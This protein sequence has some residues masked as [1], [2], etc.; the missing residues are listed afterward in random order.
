M[1]PSVYS[2][3]MRRALVAFI[4][5]FLLLSAAGCTSSADTGESVSETDVSADTAEPADSDSGDTTQTQPA[6]SSDNAGADQDSDQDGDLVEE[7]TINERFVSPLTTALGVELDQ[8][9][10]INAAFEQRAQDLITEC[11]AEAG[12]EYAPEQVGTGL[13]S[14]DRVTELQAT[15]SLDDFI[16]SY[17]YGLATLVELDFR[18]EGVLRFAER[19]LGPPA[20]TP[21]SE[22]EQEAFEIALN[23]SSVQD[24]TAEQAQDEVT[25]STDDDGQAPADADTPDSPEDWKARGCRVYGYQ[26][27]NSTELNVFQA[28][29][30]L[31]GDEYNDMFVRID[32]DPRIVAANADWASC[33]SEQG[34]D[35]ANPGEPWVD[36]SEQ[37]DALGER[38]LASPE[39]LGLFD[40]ALTA[41]VAAMT[42]VERLAF[43]EETGALQGF[44]LV[45]G[46]SDEL[47]DLIELELT[48]ARADF[49][50]A[51]TDVYDEVRFEVE[52]AFVE[53][54]AD[55]I[56]LAATG[57]TE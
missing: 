4:V 21:R 56:A 36:I 13:V 16:D 7:P 12:F 20:T 57:K 32:N 25:G 27:A 28:L 54:H 2:E 9:G 19:F 48:V 1:N 10:A 40:E 55:L 22:A 47:D 6:D 11:M 17:G 50:C 18:D 52:T 41:N 49:N 31:L 43:F 51:D 24:L 46:L 8:F 39:V 42:S 5:A 3:R 14:L 34:Y 15:L 38:F 53:E 30:D 33:M 26:T 23:G 29:D 45:P 37:S 35:Y 44:S